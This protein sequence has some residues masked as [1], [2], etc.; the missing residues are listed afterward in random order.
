MNWSR[1]QLLEF[2]GDELTFNRL[3][4]FETDGV[5]EEAASEIKRILL[6]MDAELHKEQPV[7]PSVSAAS[8]GLS[9]LLV[10]IDQKL[11]RLIR[12]LTKFGF[13]VD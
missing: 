6:K 11:D 2:V 12:A 1:P 5:P 9:P 8:S 7:P 3:V 13:E 10:T 4:S